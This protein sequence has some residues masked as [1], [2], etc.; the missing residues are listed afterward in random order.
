MAEEYKYCKRIIEDLI[1]NNR[2][3]Y[4]ANDYVYYD[5]YCPVAEEDGIRFL[6]KFNISAL[7]KNEPTFG[8]PI[9]NTGLQELFL[10]YKFIVYFGVLDVNS[11]LIQSFKDKYPEAYNFWLN[12]NKVEGCEILPRL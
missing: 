6:S 3:F 8:S 7:T 4:V 10:T 1:K 2:M 12:A 11:K 9:A 5:C